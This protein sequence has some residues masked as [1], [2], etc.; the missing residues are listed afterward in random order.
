MSKVA[1]APYQPGDAKKSS[2]KTGDIPIRRGSSHSSGIREVPRVRLGSD[3]S[4]EEKEMVDSPRVVPE[5]DDSRTGEYESRQKL[6][7]PRRE[8]Q[9]PSNE[10]SSQKQYVKAKKP[11]QCFCNKQSRC[12]LV[13][14]P[15]NEWFGHAVHVCHSEGFNKCDFWEPDNSDPCKTKCRC[16]VPGK[17]GKSRKR[18]DDGSE[19]VNFGR[20]FMSCALRKCKAFTWLLEPV[21]EDPISEQA[22]SGFTE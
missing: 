14:T 20:W 16:G 4:L 9:S 13:N 11:R 12:F 2:K 7:L 8:S 22:Y 15:S 5:R 17:R 10:A 21:W 6:V 3:E 19:T 18:N 1:F